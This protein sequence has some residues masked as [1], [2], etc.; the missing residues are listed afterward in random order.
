MIAAL[1]ILGAT[2]LLWLVSL[3][4]KDASIA[5]I[6]WGLG[7]VIVAWTAGRSP[8]LIGMTTVWGLRLALYLAYRNHGRGED[9]RY[10]AMREQNG[11]RWWWQ[12]LIQVFWLQGLLIGI[13]ALPLTAAPH[14]FS[15][16]DGV[17]VALYLVGLG[18]EAIGDFQLARF[19]AGHPG[20]VMTTGLWRFTRHPNYFG[21]FCVWW[22]IFLASGAPWTVIGPI[23]MSFLLMRVSGVPLLEKHME[24][25]PGYADYVRRTSAFFPRPPLRS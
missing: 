1:A 8:L 21:D 20:Q 12:S 5:D 14:P 9:A 23:V 18:F 25:R 19:K 4:L 3:K 11:A 2:S 10:R 24:A 16:L 6:F 7:F 22:G 17:G 15:I 13:V